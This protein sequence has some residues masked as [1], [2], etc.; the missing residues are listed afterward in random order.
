VVY[1]DALDLIFT[2]TGNGSFDPARHNWADT[3]LALHPDGSGAHGDPLD[4]WT[5]QDFDRLDA[6]DADLGSTLPAVL[7]VARGDGARHLAVQGGKD[8]LLRILDLSSLSGRAGPGHLRGEVA[9]F[10]VPQG[11]QVLT[12]PAVW[13]DTENGSAWLFIANGRGISGM[14]VMG[15]GSKPVLSARWT[16]DAGGTSPLIAND[17][18]YYAGPSGL[19][20][21]DPRTGRV[22][23]QDSGIG[24]IHW[25]SPIVADGRLYL[26]DERRTLTAWA[27]P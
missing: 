7:P 27:L 1:D 20:A 21:L 19:R 22:L 23:W 12:Q 17:V 9:V 16:S 6:E 10:P 2:A 26:T 11:G 18:L 15:E 5:P 4:T 13:T 8:A 25:E 24:E 14:Q 3:V